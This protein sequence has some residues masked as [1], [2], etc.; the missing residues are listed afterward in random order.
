[1]TYGGG[2]LGRRCRGHHRQERVNFGASDAPLSAFATTCTT[3]VQIPWALSGTAMIYHVNGVTKTL[4]MSGAVLA[5]IYLGNIKYWDDPAIK[6]INKGAG[7]PHTAITTVH[8]DSSSG[9]T[10]KLHRLPLERLDELE[11]T[12]TAPRRSSGRGPATTFRR[13]AVAAS[14]QRSPVRTVAIGY[15]DLWYGISAHLKYNVHPEQA[16]PLRAAD[17]YV[18]SR[19]RRSSTR[20]RRPTASSRS[21]TRRTPSSTSGRTRS[22][23]TRTSMSRSIRGRW[24]V[25]S[26]RS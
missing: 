1:V 17:A 9:T 22:R 15:V 8:R 23:R 20:R 24:P 10:Y 13:T 19:R 16:R 7:I 2:G 14:R 5:K 25:R 12:I 21:S 11:E 3:C 26:G 18:D 6:A 4:N